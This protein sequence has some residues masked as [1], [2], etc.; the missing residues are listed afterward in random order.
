MQV[1]FGAII[2][3]SFQW[4]ITV[5]FKP[6]NYRKWIALTFIAIM[7]GYLSFN[8]NFNLPSNK[9]INNATRTCPSA[10]IILQSLGLAEAEEAQEVIS[11]EME[12]EPIEDVAEVS[13]V[14]GFLDEPADY[15]VAGV[16]GVV[17]IIIMIVFTWLSSRFRFIFIEDIVKNDGSIKLP[18][19][20]NVF[21]GNQLFLFNILYTFAYLASIGLIIFRGYV[22][23]AVLGVSGANADRSFLKLF[24]SIIPHILILMLIIMAAGLIYF[25]VNSLV[26]PIMFKGT[27]NFKAS[28]RE[29]FRLLKKNVG[30]C[31]AFLFI[32]F[33]L[34]IGAVIA[35]GLIVVI[36]MIVV[37]ILAFL[38]TML[39]SGILA[40]LPLGINIVVGF[41][42]GLIGLAGL[43]CA[44]FILN[45]FLLPIAVF[46]QTLVLKFIAALDTSYDVF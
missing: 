9:M 31:F 44:Y 40:I 8:M 36:Y 41:I 42:F 23:L 26:I 46:F 10:G 30:N 21:I 27:G 34:G 2:K 22:S 5:L 19:S 4:M 24:L 12:Q 39:A 1:S 35:T 17:F 38:L 16:I 32:N 6:F 18:W 28:W 3:D 37:L 25:F 11:L 33:G 29:A 13:E 45:M 14:G 7:A 43:A 20:N 15:I